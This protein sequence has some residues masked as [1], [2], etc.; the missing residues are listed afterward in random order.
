VAHGA[1]FSH[2]FVLKN[3]RTGLFAM[4]LRAILVEACHG[5]PAR[6]FKNVATMRI[7][8]LHTIHPPLQ[9]L[10]MLGQIKLRMSL[11]VA[12]ETG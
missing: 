6:R 8:A 3:K 10:M 4:T 7:M 9:Y 11:Q 2:R 5:K 1:S 12:V